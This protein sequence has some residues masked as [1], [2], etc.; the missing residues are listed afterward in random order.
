MLAPQARGGGIPVG[1][2]RRARLDV[3]LD[4]GAQPRH[5]RG[6]D[7]VARRLGEGEVQLGV[8]GEEL[9]RR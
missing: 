5:H 2:A 7:D 8:E 3:G 4:G 1:D 9:G 6:D